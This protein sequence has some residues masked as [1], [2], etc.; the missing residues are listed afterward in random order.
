[1]EGANKKQELI[2][3]K[4]AKMLVNYMSRRKGDEQNEHDNGTD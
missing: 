2:I 3:I 1:M 4:Q